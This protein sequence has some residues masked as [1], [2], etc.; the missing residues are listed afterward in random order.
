MGERIS[1]AGGKAG[2]TK[3]IKDVNDHISEK[4][5]KKE[6]EAAVD[7]AS[8]KADGENDRASTDVYVKHN[9]LLHQNSKELR[10]QMT[11]SAR[12]I[13]ELQ[14]KKR[15]S[16]DPAQ[17]EELSKQIRLLKRQAGAMQGDY[18]HKTG[19]VP[20]HVQREAEAELTKV[21]ED[22]AAPADGQAGHGDPD[23]GV[24]HESMEAYKNTIV[25]AAVATAAKKVAELRQAKVDA[26]KNA[27]DHVEE[28]TKESA[29]AHDIPRDDDASD[30]E[31][32]AAADPSVNTTRVD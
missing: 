7:D 15:S 20:A 16:E 1:K 25:P 31:G 8:D 30:I 13:K 4:K 29:S 26:A 23:R 12:A 32:H 27:L 10:K 28:S 2:N 18:Y 11:A 19:E 14:T 3:T 22:A 24:P 17:T 6:K 21:A 5:E 9:S